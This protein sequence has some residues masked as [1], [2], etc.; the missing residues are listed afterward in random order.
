MKGDQVDIIRRI[1]A[2]LPA[3]WFP[4]NTPILDTLLGALAQ[5]WS[6]LYRTVGYAAEQTRIRSATGGWLDAIAEDFFG[7]RA[8]RRRDEADD[9]FR[10]RILRRLLRERGTRV[11]VRQALLELTGREPIVFEPAFCHDTGAY[12]AGGST[13][14]VPGY[15]LGYGAVGGWGSLALPFQAFVTAYR[16]I[17][18]PGIG[19]TGWG[20]GGYN[21][22]YSAYANLD[23]VRGIVTD[24]EIYAA[25]ADV[26]PVSTIAWTRIAS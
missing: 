10:N 4:D 9:G 22:A 16:P 6:T 15:A 8:R 20:A 12:G 18:S 11:A 2:V 13:P 23:A 25:V 21:L 26:M 3:G 14:S 17:R 1:R 19:S 24:A 7:R 5:T